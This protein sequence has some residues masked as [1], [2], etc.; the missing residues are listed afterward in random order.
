MIQSLVL[1]MERLKS[2]LRENLRSIYLFGSTTLTD[3]QLGWSDIDVLIFT[4]QPPTDSEASAL[5]TIRQ[6]LLEEYPNNQYFGSLEG[7]VVYF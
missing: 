3:F 1:F 4:Y 6:R 5:V 2:I 7:A